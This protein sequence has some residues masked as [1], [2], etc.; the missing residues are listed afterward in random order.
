[1]YIAKNHDKGDYLGEVHRIASIITP[2]TITNITTSVASVDSKIAISIIFS[3]CSFSIV[4]IVFVFI[5]SIPQ[6]RGC[7]VIDSIFKLAAIKGF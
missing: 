5:V 1:M 3:L 4:S 7:R 6:V 2:K